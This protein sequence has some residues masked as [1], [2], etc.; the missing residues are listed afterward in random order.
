MKNVNSIQIDNNNNHD[1]IKYKDI[2]K[3]DRIERFDFE[4]KIIVLVSNSTVDS[5]NN[6]YFYILSP[7]NA[8]WWYYD[9]VSR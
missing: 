3:N 5:T 7:D 1:I 2:N 8:I 4:D 9:I 6:L